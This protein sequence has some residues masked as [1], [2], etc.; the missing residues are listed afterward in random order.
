MRYASI[1]NFAFARGANKYW[2]TKEAM[3]LWIEKQGGTYLLYEEDERKGSKGKM[4]GVTFV[5]RCTEL[6]KGVHIPAN[7]GK[8]QIA[9]IPFMC[10]KKCYRGYANAQALL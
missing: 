3:A 6:P 2:P 1:V 10:L 4:A 7:M 5:W 8:G 9:Y